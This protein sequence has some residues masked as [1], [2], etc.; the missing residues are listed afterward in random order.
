M[1]IIGSSTSVVSPT[2]WMVQIK[3]P[4]SKKRRI[5]RKWS[6]NP[7]NFAIRSDDL[8]Y[9]LGNT[10]YVSKETFEKLKKMVNL[11]N[12]NMDLSKIK[13][14]SMLHNHPMMENHLEEAFP[15]NFGIGK[16]V[17]VDKDQ[18]EGVR[19]L[20]T[21]IDVDNPGVFIPMKEELTADEQL[22]MNMITE[23]YSEF[24]KLQLTHST[25]RVEWV[26]HIHGLQK[27]LGMRLLRREHPG[28]FSSIK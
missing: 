4:K 8:T 14:H 18:W 9:Q 25:E 2:K 19:E 7:L 24:I 23:A 21:R 5:R 12:K 11:I 17:V 16:H 27:L 20:L 10:L 3:F 13:K 15:T 26:Q 22:I 1:W 28:F 6:K